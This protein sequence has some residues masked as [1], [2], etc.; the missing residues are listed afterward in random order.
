MTNPTTVTQLSSFVHLQ[1][2]RIKK[3]ERL[4]IVTR[5]SVKCTNISA[6]GE[7]KN[8]GERTGSRNTA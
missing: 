5:L 2:I 8:K 7:K 1:N 3:L 6:E 4:L